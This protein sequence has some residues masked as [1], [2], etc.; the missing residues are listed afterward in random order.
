MAWKTR[1]PRNTSGGDILLSFHATATPATCHTFLSSLLVC[2]GG[3][4]T[5]HELFGHVC[6][7]ICCAFCSC[8]CMRQY[9][10]SVVH[11]EEKAE[12]GQGGG[13]GGG[14]A[15]GWTRQTSVSGCH[16]PTTYHSSTSL[17]PTY[18]FSL[19]WESFLYSCSLYLWPFLSHKKT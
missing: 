3:G 19:P 18:A 5:W 7:P 8:M 15:G 6:L 10:Q 14:G 2:F 9:R 13:A 11:C 4:W 1:H 17:L 16:P 12:G